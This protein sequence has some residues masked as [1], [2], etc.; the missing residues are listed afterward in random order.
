MDLLYIYINVSS[1]YVINSIFTIEVMAR[2]DDEDDDDDDDDEEGGGRRRLSRRQMMRM[3]NQAI[4]GAVPNHGGDE[5]KVK[6]KKSSE[7]HIKRR[8]VR[9][10]NHD[11]V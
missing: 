10:T 9:K 1:T 5:D 2:D 8:A 6:I 7:S 4:N 11:Y 3:R